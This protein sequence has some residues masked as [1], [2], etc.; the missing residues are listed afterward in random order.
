MRLNYNKKKFNLIFL[1]K[2]VINLIDKVFSFRTLNNVR[3]YIKKLMNINN[4]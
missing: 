3:V 1:N 4:I 2:T